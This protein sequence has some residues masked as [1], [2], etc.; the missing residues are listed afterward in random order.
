[1]PAL[2]TIQHR[3]SAAGPGALSW[4]TV[5]P[6]L[7]SGEIGYVTT[8]TNAGMFKIGNGTLA[9][10]DLPFAPSG[11][12]TVATT[13]T[14]IV[15][16]ALG[17]LP[18]Q[19]GVSGTT[20]LGIGTTGYILQV[21][22][23]VPAWTLPKLNAFASTSSSELLGTISDETGSGS[24]VFATNPVLI[25]PSVTSAGAIF[26]GTS[27][28]STTL[29]SGLTGTTSYTLTLPPEN[30][31]LLTATTAGTTYVAKAGSTMSG[32][33]AMGANPISGVTLLSAA[34]VTATSISTVSA[35]STY[36]IVT[37]TSAGVLSSVVS[38]PVAN[39][40][41]GGT[42]VTT[43][44]S[45]LRIFVQSADPSLSITPQANDLWFW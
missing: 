31:T 13:A 21:V 11:L 8:G 24:L 39:G 33:L 38:V 12:A 5:N 1:M 18:Y 26:K 10:N 29:V 43:A 16:G 9:W 17:S 34:N 19:T 28:G 35:T 40:G 25:T 20:T 45:G 37:N 3:R 14:N 42:D 6:I 41:T 36:G 2:T 23:G 44:R 32:A 15:G 7:A 22:A 27:T 30:A 4:Y